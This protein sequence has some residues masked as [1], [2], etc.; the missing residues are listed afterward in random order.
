VEEKDFFDQLD[1]E[2]AAQ[3]PKYAELLRRNRILLEL[4]PIRKT[5]GLTQ[6]E[7]AQRM[8]VVREVVARI[9]T[10]PSRVSMDK[11]FAYA[12]ALG[13]RIVV[14]PPEAA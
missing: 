7:I 6:Q 2:R 4:L 3:D 10:S 13:A 9:E 1:E 12:E 5:L 11:I 8:G 14:Q